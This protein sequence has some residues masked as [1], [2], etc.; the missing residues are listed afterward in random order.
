[1][2]GLPGLFEAITKLELTST[3]CTCGI[4]ANYGQALRIAVNDELNRLER[5]L[6][7]AID[8]LSPG[9]RIAVISFHRY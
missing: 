8:A 7:D 1:M 4:C 3:D 5:A 9:G 6:P 2:T